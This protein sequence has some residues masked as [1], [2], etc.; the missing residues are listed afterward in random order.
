MN[1]G[2]LNHR[3]VLKGLQTI[4][5]E[6]GGV[7]ESFVVKKSC[8]AHIRTVR[9]YGDMLANRDMNVCL[10][11]ITVRDENSTAMMPRKGDRI[12]SQGRVFSVESVSL[13]EQGHVVMN[14]REES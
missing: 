11:E 13:P 2:K 8:W 3:I 12:E 14:C 6:G 9:A 7:E 4:R 5:D 1:P 10:Y